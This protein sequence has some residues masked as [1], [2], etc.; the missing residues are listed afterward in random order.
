MNFN[1]P[2]LG[3]IQGGLIKSKC[4]WGGA[5]S[6]GRAKSR[7]YGRQIDVDHV[8]TGKRNLQRD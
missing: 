1:K 2:P 4:S 3:L 8:P 7:I 6:R 5:Y